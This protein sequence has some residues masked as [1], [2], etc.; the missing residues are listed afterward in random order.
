MENKTFGYVSISCAGY[1]QKKGI[2]WWF[3]SPYYEY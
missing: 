3:N 2:D 1:N